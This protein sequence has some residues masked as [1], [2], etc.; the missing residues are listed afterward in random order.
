MNVTTAQENLRQHL[1]PY[2]EHK[3]YEEK[4][5]LIFTRQTNFGK[6]AFAV[7]LSGDEKRV[8]VRLFA[9]IRH[10]LVELT[11]INSLGLADYFKSESY[12]LMVNWEHLDSVRFSQA[13]PCSR[14]TDITT[15]GDMAI[16]FMD[17]KGF[18]FLNR[19]RQMSSL[20][21]LFNDSPD[22]LA[23]WTNHSY[24][25]RFRAMVIAKLRGREDYENLFEL[26]RT[27]LKNRGFDGVIA[28][29]FD[30]TFAHLKKLSLN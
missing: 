24:L 9:G 3:Q 14:M 21:R 25:N 11:L 18:D 22:K 27:Y 16:D 10:D 7:T 19:Y 15:V 20:D 29:K 28:T 26:H 13:L 6:S 23:K 12:T 4:R 30:T 2:F 17:Q 1:H 8:Y 5:P